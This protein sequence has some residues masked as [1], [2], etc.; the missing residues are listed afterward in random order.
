VDA[1]KTAILGTISQTLPVLEAHIVD[2]TD[3]LESLDI[4]VSA[5]SN[6]QHISPGG[7]DSLQTS[8]RRESALEVDRLALEAEKKAMEQSQQICATAEQEM[9]G[10]F[11]TLKSQSVQGTFSGPNFSGF[12]IV[13]NTATINWGARP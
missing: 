11:P 7:Y 3:S 2:I 1:A 13:Q 9:K 12:Q 4:E 8:G 5:L 10:T 6:S